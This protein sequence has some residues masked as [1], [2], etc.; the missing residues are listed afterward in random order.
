MKWKA[1]PGEFD[2]DLFDLDE[3][4]RNS[5]GSD[6]YDKLPEKLQN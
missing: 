4:D 3:F 5:S 2:S 1:I 6:D